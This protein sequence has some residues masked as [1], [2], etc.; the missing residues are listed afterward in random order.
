MYVVIYWT[1]DGNC[2]QTEKMS[3]DAASRLAESMSAEQEA[4]LMFVWR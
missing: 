2:H 4:R 3:A 1:R